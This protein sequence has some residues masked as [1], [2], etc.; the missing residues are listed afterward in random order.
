MNTK[1]FRLF[2]AKNILEMKESLD[3]TM[4]LAGGC[5]LTVNR[6]AKMSALELLDL[7]ST[8]NIRFCYIKS[9]A[10]EET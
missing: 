6:L 3:Y 5:P 2:V 8:N 1:L 10:R 4:T 9:I 7:L